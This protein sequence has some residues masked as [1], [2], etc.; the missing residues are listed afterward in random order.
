MAYKQTPGRGNMPKTGRGMSPALMGKSPMKQMHGEDAELTATGAASRKKVQAGANKRAANS[1]TD[2]QGISIDPKTGKASAKQYEKKFVPG[3][4]GTGRSS[5]MVV[6]GSGKTSKVASTSKG[7]DYGNEALYK[8][9][10]KDSTATMNARNANARFYNVQAG[11]E[12]PN[13]KEVEA[14]KNR[15]FFKK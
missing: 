6:D 13:A 3:G 10:K 9:F 15:G 8:E 12:K 5:A 14:G 7:A 1:K 2:M 4:K 11:K